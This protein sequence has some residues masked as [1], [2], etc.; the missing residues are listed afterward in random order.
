LSAT[1]GGGSFA[2]ELQLNKTDRMTSTM[3]DGMRV[4]AT[5]TIKLTKC[6]SSGRLMFVRPSLA[7]KLFGSTTTLFAPVRRC[8]DRQVLSTTRP[9][10]PSLS[11]IQSPMTYG[12]PS[13]SAMPE[14]TSLSV[15]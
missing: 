13:V 12:R 10:V 7:R 9:S 4:G 15:F 8:V 3:M 6:V 14:N 11:R 5:R 2:M 1:I